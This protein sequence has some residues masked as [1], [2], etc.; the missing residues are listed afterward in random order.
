MPRGNSFGRCELIRP[1]S[2]FFFF[3]PFLFSK[4]LI[5]FLSSFPLLRFFFSFSFSFS[6][7]FSFFFFFPP[8]VLTPRTCSRPF[9]YFLSLS[10]SPSLQQPVVSM[11]SSPLLEY[12]HLEISYIPRVRFTSDNSTINTIGRELASIASRLERPS[13]LGFRR[14]RFKKFTL[15]VHDSLREPIS[16]SLAS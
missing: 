8:F 10:L 9:S 11:L 15:D 12:L 2:T 16:I 14:I 6:F 7:F 4:S 13:F 3:C 5:P 1:R